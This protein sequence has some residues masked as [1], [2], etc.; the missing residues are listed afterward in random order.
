[1]SD[2]AIEQLEAELRESQFK[3]WD[4]ET[5][6]ADRHRAKIEALTKPDNSKWRRAWLATQ[7]LGMLLLAIIG[8]QAVM[9][10]VGLWALTGEFL[11]LVLAP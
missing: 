6:L 3:P 9:L 2:P 7:E 8:F 10:T 5:L 4:V 11:P 1:M